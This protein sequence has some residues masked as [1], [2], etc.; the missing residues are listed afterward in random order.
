[1][2]ENEIKPVL[3]IEVNTLEM[4]LAN[5]PRPILVATRPYS[6]LRVEMGEVALY[7]QSAIDRLTVERDAAV[8]D[9]RRLHDFVDVEKNALIAAASRA[10]RCLAWAG[11]AAGAVVYMVHTAADRIIATIRSERP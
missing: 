10:R 11:F 5:T 6:R 7:D 3:T 4:A 8:A 1:M 9:A 2:S